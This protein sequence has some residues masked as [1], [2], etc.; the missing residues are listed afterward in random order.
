M[1]K[2][3]NRQ[4]L[5]INEESQYGGKGLRFLYKNAFGR[6]LLKFFA[7]HAF[8]NFMAWYYG[9]KM[10]KRKIKPFVKKYN[11][12]ISDEKLEKYQNF[13]EFFTRIDPKRSF[14]NSPNVL[15]SPA[16]SRVLHYR[17]TDDLLVTIKNSVY[18][19]ADLI[20]EK[21]V[22]KYRDGHCL[23]FRLTMDD[24]HHYCYVDD[25]KL[26]R[27]KHIPG[28]LHT[29]SS[30]SKDYEVFIHNDRV[31]NV[32]QTEHFGEIVQ[33]EIGAMLVGRIR[34]RN[35][36]EFAKGDEKGYFELGGSTIVLLLD[37]GA[38]KVDEDILINSEQNIE[39]KVKY[40]EKVGQAC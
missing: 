8:S 19:I 15:I 27:R 23:V 35:V 1:S 17:I 24:H 10:S 22:E 11:I 31:V 28:Q 14:D 9:D 38:V 13:A 3:L 20:G 5:A 18:R 12:D 32:L 34:N 37:K 30:I 36:E 26:V 25:G 4:T 16:D 40:G 33:V 6:L 29:V 21:D 7:G 2:Y 39:V